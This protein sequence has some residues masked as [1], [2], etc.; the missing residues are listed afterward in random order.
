MSKKTPSR[1]LSKSV[2]RRDVMKFTLAGA[3]L[4]AL[5]SLNQSLLV[6]A[7]GEPI[8]NHKRLVVI[9]C[10][11]GYDGLNMVVPTTSSTY[12]LQRPGIAI[13]DAEGLAMN[14]VTGMKLHP[15]FTAFQSIFN[16]DGKGAVF[17]MVGY[18][19]ASRSHF[20]SQDYYSLGVVDEFAPLGIDESG[21]LA[22]FADTHAPSATGAVAVG[23][24][25][26]MD[27]EGGLQTPLILGSVASFNFQNDPGYTNNHL[28]RLETVQ[29]ILDGYAGSSGATTETADAI[30]QGMSLA[31]QLQAA[32]A[33]YNTPFMDSYPNQIGRTY[34][35]RPGRHLRDISMMIQAGFDTRVFF[36][37]MGGWD[38]HG[39]QGG[40]TTNPARQRDLIYYLDKGIENFVEDLKFMGAYDDT[41]ILVVTE[42]G[43]TNG[44]NGSGGTDH[45]K[46]NTFFAVGGG[47]QSGEY[48]TRPTDAQILSGHDTDPADG[49]N[50]LYPYS[51]DF[52]DIY[53]EAIEDHMGFDASVVLPEPQ[54]IDTDIGFVA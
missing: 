15:E 48:G 21:W 32:L 30:D 28:Y 23:V 53:R 12:Y 47:T 25:R 38:T 2:T 52:R 44:E 4:T 49:K 35:S 13:S 50:W 29:G 22:R 41:M 18:P 24:G 5:G 16:N 26:P 27:V 37:G 17:H 54:D 36:T 51:L 11:G 8:P 34:L 45:G 14:G 42:F 19:D 10:Y 39:N 3:G 7:T 33:S 31:A 6:P 40:G 20:S 46:A 1:H 9:Y 43:R